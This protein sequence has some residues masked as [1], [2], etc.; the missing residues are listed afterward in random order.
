[1]QEDLVHVLESTIEGLDAHMQWPNEQRREELSKLFTGIFHGCIGIADV[2]EYRIVKF[3]DTVKERRSW[4]GKK[5]INSY[6]FLSVIDHSGRFIFVRLSLGMNDREVYTTSPL[7]LCE[8][9]FFSDGQFIASDGAFEGDGR[10]ICSYKKPGN[11]ENNV[12]FRKTFLPR[13][14]YLSRLLLS[15]SLHFVPRLNRQR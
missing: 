12:T 14:V 7:Y 5:K 1:M 8:G 11:D 2:K 15:C 13:G 6:K 10:F 9:D 3:K 4:S